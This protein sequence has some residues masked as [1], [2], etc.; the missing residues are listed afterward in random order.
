MAREI[1]NYVM[2]T[3]GL[4]VYLRQEE[5]CEKVKTLF[6]DKYNRFFM[7]AVNVGEAYYDTLRKDKN[8]AQERK[9]LNRF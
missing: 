4:L 1:V 9:R 5:G 8:E 7:H 2:D 6:R 3:C